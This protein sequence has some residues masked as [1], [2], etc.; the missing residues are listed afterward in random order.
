MARVE[1]PAD[2][3]GEGSRGDL[4]SCSGM[5]GCY[6]ESSGDPLTPMGNPMTRFRPER[7]AA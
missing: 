3:S 2:R 5:A 1:K 6:T 4:G 7:F